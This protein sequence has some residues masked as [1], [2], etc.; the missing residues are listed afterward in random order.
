MTV[1]DLTVGDLTVGD[2]AVGALL[3]EFW[4]SEEV[5]FLGLDSVW[6]DI[7]PMEIIPRLTTAT[8]DTSSNLFVENFIEHF[9]EHFCSIY[10][11][12]PRSNF[13]ESIEIVQS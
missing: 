6:A 8:V 7:S 5:V 11:P 3:V 2:L 1:G 4:G 10:I 9:V 12:H 13:A